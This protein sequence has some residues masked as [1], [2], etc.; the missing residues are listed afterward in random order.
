MELLTGPA[1]PR[2]I[3]PQ[4]DGRRVKVFN[5]VAR[6][7]ICCRGTGLYAGDRYTDPTDARAFE[8]GLH[9]RSAPP[10]SRGR[11]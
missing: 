3:C 9:P 1:L 11:G 7:C 10:A 6:P 2:Q 5:A 8:L 4:C